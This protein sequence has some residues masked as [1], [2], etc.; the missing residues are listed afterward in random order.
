MA[1]SWPSFSLSLVVHIKLSRKANDVFVQ[2]IFYCLKR[3]DRE[4]RNAARSLSVFFAWR[5]MW[6]FIYKVIME[7][8][9]KRGQTTFSAVVLEWVLQLFMS[10]TR[11][12]QRI[13]AHFILPFAITF[14]VNQFN[15]HFIAF[16]CLSFPLPLILTEN[17]W[18]E[19]GR[20]CLN[21]SWISRERWKKDQTFEAARRMF[22]AVRAWW[23]VLLEF[24]IVHV[25][26]VHFGEFDK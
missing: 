24:F 5:E 17:T 23:W 18:N 7:K 13:M 12:R 16:F 10:C 19:L 26:R 20:W 25:A 1:L 9:F 3:L 2:L 11:E 6:K 14:Y 15:F 22:V 8:I 4:R 21:F